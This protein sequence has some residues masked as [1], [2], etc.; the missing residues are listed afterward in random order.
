[1]LGNQLGALVAKMEERPPACATVAPHQSG[2]FEDTLEAA[3]TPY[4]KTKPAT[5]Y[6]GKHIFAL[7]PPEEESAAEPAGVGIGTLALTASGGPLVVPVSGTRV[8]GRTADAPRVRLVFSSGG[9]TETQLAQLALP[10]L[11]VTAKNTAVVPTGAAAN[12]AALRLALKASAN[13]FSGSFSFKDPN[14]LK[15][16]AFVTRKAVFAGVLLGQQGVGYFLF[17]GIKTSAGAPAA[18]LSGLVT[19]EPLS[20]AE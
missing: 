16:G 10:A 2:L 15:P 17:P 9:L 19:L 18:T 20:A 5:A 7:L 13:T 4:G 8:L 12:P 14:P 11:S 3:P 6:V 1:M